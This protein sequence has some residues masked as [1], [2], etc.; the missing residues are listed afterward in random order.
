[1]LLFDAGTSACLQRYDGNNWVDVKLPSEVPSD[2]IFVVNIG[3]CFSDLCGGK[4]PSTLH[5][6]MPRNDSGSMPLTPRNC[7]ALFVGLKPDQTLHIDG[8]AITY[9]EWRKRKIASAQKALNTSTS[10]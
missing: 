7:L 9:E 5:R 2:P 1:V 3:D 4:L 6:V 10:V 8:T